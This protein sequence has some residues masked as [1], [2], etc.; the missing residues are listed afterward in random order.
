MQD[1]Q[2]AATQVREAF[3]TWIVSLDLLAN[4]YSGY[5]PDVDAQRFVEDAL[6]IFPKLNCGLASVYLQKVL[7]GGEIVRGAYGVNAHTFLVLDE[8]VVVDITADQYGGP[9]VYVGELKF[10]WSIN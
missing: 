7:G 5:N 6:K 10:P 1:L 9:K 2:I 3:E 4:L 8:N